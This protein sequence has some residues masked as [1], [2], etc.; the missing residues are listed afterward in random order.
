MADD[1]A[2]HRGEDRL[3]RLA[4]PE[5][6]LLIGPLLRHVDAHAYR[7]HHFPVQVVQR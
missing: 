2:V 7:P 4:L 6:F 3:Q 1:P 5:E